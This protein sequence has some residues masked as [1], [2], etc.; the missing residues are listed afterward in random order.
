MDRRIMQ[1]QLSLSFVGRHLRAVALGMTVAVILVHAICSNAQTTTSQINGIVTDS[2]GALVIGANIKA[3]N[4]AT[5]IAYQATT[6]NLGA[7]HITN[8]PPGKYTMEVTKTGICGS[9]CSAF[10]LV[11]GQAVQNNITLAVGIAEQTVSVN[12]SNLLLDTESSHYQQLIEGQQI[13]DMPLNGREYLQLALLSAGTV[14]VTV[15]GISSPASGWS[16]AGTVAVGHKR[17]AGKTIIAFSMTASKRAMHGTEQQA[18]L[19]D[20]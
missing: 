8:L 2:A 9:T 17:F 12:A 3:T 19:P 11:V 16:A 10:T 14:P 20:P 18:L 7:Y 1:L 6:D 5:D 13:T 4:S 15:S